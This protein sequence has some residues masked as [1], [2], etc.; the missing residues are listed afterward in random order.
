MSS[1]TVFGYGSLIDL[2]S[3]KAT[4]PDAKDIRSCFVRGF[5]RN[6]SLWDPVG[7]NETNLDLKGLPFCALD[8][9]KVNDPSKIVNGIV[10]RIDESRFNNLLKREQEYEVRETNVYDWNTKTIL[11]PAF[12]FSSN[13]NNGKY[14][15]GSAAQER[16][17]ELCLKGAKTFG[18]DF[19]KTFLETTYLNGKKLTELHLKILGNK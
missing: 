2:D 19:Y 6:F 16:Y 10:F 14:N 18:E 17:L 15:F 8:I 11:G 9:Q 1:K 13:K 12:L 7:F 4:V 5:T 3:L